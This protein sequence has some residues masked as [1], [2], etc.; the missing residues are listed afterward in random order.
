MKTSN[1]AWQ[2][3]SR[4]WPKPD[5]SELWRLDGSPA[6]NL[7]RDLAAA[8]EPRPFQ[9]AVELQPLAVR[10]ALPVRQ[11]RKI[12][13]HKNRNQVLDRRIQRCSLDISLYFPL[14]IFLENVI[15]LCP[16]AAQGFHFRFQYFGID[17]PGFNGRPRLDF[18]M[19][20]EP[21]WHA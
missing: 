3:K 15:V 21:M 8:Q 5:N 17:V 1:S 9:P 19:R 2:R 11:H 10:V 6:A 7:H 12:H 16:I 13:G 14:A 18:Y 4:Q 20:P